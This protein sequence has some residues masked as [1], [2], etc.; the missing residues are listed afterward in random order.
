[1]LVL[2]GDAAA[3]ER[4]ESD[5]WGLGA[6]VPVSEQVPTGDH[7][8]PPRLEMAASTTQTTWPIS[9]GRFL[10]P[11]SPF[12]HAGAEQGRKRVCSTA[13]SLPAGM[14]QGEFDI[15]GLQRRLL[16]IAD[17]APS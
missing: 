3:K 11:Q 7:I 13:R 4:K 2:R 5:L 6:V 15:K 1:M 8:L 14:G 16:S 17:W 9:G 10:Q 12:E